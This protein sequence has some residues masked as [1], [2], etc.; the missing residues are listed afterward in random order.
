[1]PADVTYAPTRPPIVAPEPS[2]DDPL[3]VLSRFTRTVPAMGP[4]GVAAALR[5]ER[6]MVVIERVARLGAAGHGAG[7]TIRGSR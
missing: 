6:P 3:T 2:L 5:G 4:A 1:M 7:G